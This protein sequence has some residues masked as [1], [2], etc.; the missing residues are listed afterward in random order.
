[1]TWSRFGQWLLS[2]DQG[3]YIKYWQQNMNNVHMFPAHNSSIRG[4]TCCP[5]DTMFATCSDDHTIQIWD[6][7]RPTRKNSSTSSTRYV[8]TFFYAVCEN[9]QYFFVVLSN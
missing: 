9:M 7:L 6:F 3:G 5:D 4:I 1:M 8:R 2:G